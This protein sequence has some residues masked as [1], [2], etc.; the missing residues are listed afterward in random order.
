MKLI[1]GLLLASL[2]YAND[3]YYEYGQKV[4]VSQSINKRSKD[5]S[6]EYYQKQDGNLVGIK[7]DEILTQCNVGV[8]CAKVLAKY[9]F[10]SISKL[11]TTIFL[12]KL[13]PT[14][15]VFNFSQILYNDSDIAFAHPN[16]VKERKGR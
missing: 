13:T 6:V 16:F 15:D 2:L 12:V 1:V 4:E 9:D 8:D 14:Q 3:F 11:S 5:N 7:K 10:A